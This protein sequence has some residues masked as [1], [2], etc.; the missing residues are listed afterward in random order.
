MWICLSAVTNES[1]GFVCMKV[2][3]SHVNVSMW[4]YMST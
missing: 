3:M 1:C 2:C 4:R